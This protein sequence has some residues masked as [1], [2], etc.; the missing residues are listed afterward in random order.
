MLSYPK[1]C[2]SDHEREEL[3]A[4]YLPWCETLTV[5]EPLSVPECRDP[6]DRPFLEL[7][8]AVQAD[9]LVRGDKDTLVLASDFSVP[10]LTP[11]GLEGR[12]LLPE[13]GD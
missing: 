7:A 3:L 1:F 2:L 10:F 11:M 12:L 6:H 8:L 4:D 13:F 5:A 9:P